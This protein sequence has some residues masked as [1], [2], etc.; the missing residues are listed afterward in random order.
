MGGLLW[1]QMS[2]WLVVPLAPAMLPLVCWHQHPILCLTLLWNTT[3]MMIFVGRATKMA[4]I[5]V[6]TNEMQD[7]THFQQLRDSFMSRLLDFLS[8]PILAI[9]HAWQ[10]SSHSVAPAAAMVSLSSGDSPFMG[11]LASSSF[12]C[13]VTKISHLSSA[14]WH[15]FWHLHGFIP[16]SLI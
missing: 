12:F 11:I 10:H 9:H 8:I 3:Q 7:G 15:L 2:L 5:M 4:S 6:L 1:R 16:S 14:G 13:S